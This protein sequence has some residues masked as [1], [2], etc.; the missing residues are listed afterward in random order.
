MKPPRSRRPPSLAER[1]RSIRTVTGLSQRALSEKSGVSFSFIS[2]IE[3]GER[4]PTVETIRKL[5]E[6]L[7]VSAHYL[8]TG[9]AE[10]DYVYQPTGG[11]HVQ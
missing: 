7:E 6:A 11:R 1:L 8:E 2:R 3:S 5:A 10:G 4:R 9:D